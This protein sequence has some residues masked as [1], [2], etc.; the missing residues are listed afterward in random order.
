[1][2]R[3]RGLALGQQIIL[4]LPSGTMEFDLGSNRRLR[5]VVG[6][7]DEVVGYVAEL[8]A[9]LAPATLSATATVLVQASVNVTLAPA[10]LDAAAEVTG[11]PLSQP[12]LTGGVD[13][14]ISITENA[15]GTG[16]VAFTASKPCRIY[17]G[18]AAADTLSSDPAEAGA[19]LA[20]GTG[21][22]GNGSFLV[23]RG[24]NNRAVAL[25]AGVLNTGATFYVIARDESASPESDWSNILKDTSVSVD[26]ADW[27]VTV[28][29]ASATIL[30]FIPV[31]TSPDWAVT[32]GN[33]SATV[34]SYP[35]AA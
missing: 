20:A 13:G 7:A 1:V 3:L 33:A 17:W 25:P 5:A 21:L 28:G 12:V 14:V 32:P 4:P 15:D 27:Q 2:R 6:I 16:S 31:P 18:L 9:T 8:D 34:T 35:G 26:T 30:S 24:V 19:D 29:N 10:T 11:A 23:Q 22:L